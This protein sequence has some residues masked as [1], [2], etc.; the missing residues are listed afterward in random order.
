MTDIN[1]T[2][3][4]MAIREAEEKGFHRQEFEAWFFKRRAE[5]R[6]LGVELTDADANSM[7]DGWQAACELT[8]SRPAD[9]A[10]STD[11]CRYVELP[12]RLRWMLDERPHQPV[13]IEAGARA[14]AKLIYR[15]EGLETLGGYAGEDDYA[16]KEHDWYESW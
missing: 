9:A 4:V 15:E 1:E 12:P 14:I 5:W 2:A 8:G 13:D 3:L 11:K 6:A 16:K 7:W 10:Q